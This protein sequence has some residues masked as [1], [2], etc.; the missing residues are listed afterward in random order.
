M[1]IPQNYLIQK[2]STFKILHSTSLVGRDLNNKNIKGSSY[3]KKA[4]AQLV[5]EG[6]NCELIQVKDVD[7]K[8]MRYLQSQADLIIDQ[9]IYGSWGSTSLEGVALGKPVICYFKSEWKK[10]YIDNFGIDIWPFIEA[11]PQT[12]YSVIK[13]LLDNPMLI[14]K[15]SKLS[16]EFAIKY[17]DVK[18]RKSLY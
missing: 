8:N 18:K 9:L 17:L 6:Y 10:N 1:E 7:S 4:I 11:N 14:S 12:I 13:D 2:T 15:Y 3:I 16:R 5:N